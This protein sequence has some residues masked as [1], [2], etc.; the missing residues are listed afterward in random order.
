MTTWKPTLRVLPGGT[1]QLLVTGPEGDELVKARL[2]GQ[3]RHPRAL[4]TVLEGLALWSGTPLC[5]AISADI[6]VD[7]SLGLGAFSDLEELWPEESA[8]VQFTFIVPSRR[9]R[10]IAG[11]GDFRHLR[12]LDRAR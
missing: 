5:A 12:Q 8:L 3:S 2:P 7:N 11:V 4:L 6:P 1:M 9:G 10:R